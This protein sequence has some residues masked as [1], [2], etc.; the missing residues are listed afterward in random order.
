MVILLLKIY[1]H[2]NLIAHSCYFSW[3]TIVSFCLFIIDY[4]LFIYLLFFLAIGFNT[5]SFLL[6]DIYFKLM[7]TTSMVHKL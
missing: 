6:F 3:C 1:E 4:R 7:G 5:G 2:Y